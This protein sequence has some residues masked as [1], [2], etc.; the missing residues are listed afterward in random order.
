[1][2]C[3]RLFLSLRQ[4]TIGDASSDMIHHVAL[5][6][7]LMRPPIGLDQ[8]KVKTLIHGRRVL[9]T[10]A[11]GSIGSELCRQI[12]DRSP[13]GLRMLDQHENGLH[14]VA[15]SDRTFAQPAVG[16]ITDASHRRAIEGG[17]DEVWL[18]RS[19]AGHVHGRGHPGDGAGGRS[20]RARPIA[21][22]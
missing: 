16:D 5:E 21:R 8:A 14:S 12:A 4:P 17:G 13:A 2:T 1:V 20:V 22:R 9:V 19:S 15:M 3:P 7:L 6:E 10:G 18:I 11:G